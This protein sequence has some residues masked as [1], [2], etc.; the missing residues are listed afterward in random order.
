MKLGMNIVFNN[1]AYIMANQIHMDSLSYIFDGIRVY[2]TPLSS[3]LELGP[4][5]CAIRTSQGMNPSIFGV[6]FAKGVCFFFSFLQ[7]IP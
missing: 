3:M 2:I 1:P 7:K 6:C 4:L 5:L